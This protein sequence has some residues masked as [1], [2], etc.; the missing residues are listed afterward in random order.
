MNSN[1]IKTHWNEQWVAVDTKAPTKKH[2][3]AISNY[4]RI[5]S[6]SKE[7]GNEVLLKG[8]VTNSFTTLNLKLVDN[9]PHGIYI[10]KFVAQHF[11]ENDDPSK[12]FVVHIDEDKKN[13][14]WKNLKWV[15]QEEL[16]EL[17]IKQGVFDPVKRRKAGVTKLTE[18]QVKLIK[19]RLK[20]GKTKKKIIA[21][22]FNISVTQIKRIESGEN[23]GYLNSQEGLKGS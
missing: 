22:N 14:Y 20:S 2:N 13:N 19:K 4:G 12:K 15:N 6:I 18:T 11:I 8:S 17:Q 1:K 5:K 16:L 9:I 10:H 23:W 7:T 21:K 3:Y